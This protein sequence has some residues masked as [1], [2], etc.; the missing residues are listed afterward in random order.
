MR[1]GLQLAYQGL[2]IVVSGVCLFSFSCSWDWVA[3]ALVTQ[4]HVMGVLVTV[5][6]GCKLYLCHGARSDTPHSLA[7]I[8]FVCVQPSKVRSVCHPTKYAQC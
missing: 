8:R 1:K 6:C 3:H 5:L 7:L 4:V 2:N